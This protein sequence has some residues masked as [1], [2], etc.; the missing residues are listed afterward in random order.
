MDFNTIMYLLEEKCG[1]RVRA[2]MVNSMEPKKN[3]LLSTLGLNKI[4]D[5][6][7]LDKTMVH[8]RDIYLFLNLSIENLLKVAAR[9]MV[10]K[11]LHYS[12]L[13]MSLNDPSTSD[14]RPFR[15]HS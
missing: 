11:E 6:L 2:F 3:A 10:K 8:V 5:T 9:F 12:I 4:I 1:F 15:F 13:D 14:G 7:S